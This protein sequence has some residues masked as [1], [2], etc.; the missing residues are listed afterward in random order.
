MPTKKQRDAVLSRLKAL[1][2]AIDEE[3]ARNPDF[4]SRIEK[5]LLSPD[6]IVATHKKGGSN[7]KT[8][9][10]NILDVLHRDGEPEARKSL[11]SQTND[12][13]AKLAAAD[14]VKKLN[15][16]KSMERD[17]LIDLLIE[18]ATNRLKQGESFTKG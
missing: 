10:L 15:E 16:A 5:I 1:V 6:A 12:E 14:G 17:A 7:A 8:P 2:E 9:A 3:G 4:F 11:E 13:L 18:T